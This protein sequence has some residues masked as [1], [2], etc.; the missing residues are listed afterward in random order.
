[1]KSL[2]STRHPEGYTP[3]HSAR[4]RYSRSSVV[5]ARWLLVAAILF[6]LA[7]WAAAWLAYKVF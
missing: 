7:A 2:L 5:G 4:E 1:M 3:R 6:T